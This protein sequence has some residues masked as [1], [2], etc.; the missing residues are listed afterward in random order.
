VQSEVGRGTTFTISLPAA[1]AVAH[2]HEQEVPATTV[3]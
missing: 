1:E 3:A 2:V